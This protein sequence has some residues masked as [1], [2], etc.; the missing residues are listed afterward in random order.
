MTT[1]G[2]E[3]RTLCD[4]TGQPAGSSLPLC[5]SATCTRFCSI[6]LLLAGEASWTVGFVGHEWDVDRRK[7]RKLT[8]LE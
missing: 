5:S 3:V 7:R 4:G 1:S 2:V 8:L 6:F